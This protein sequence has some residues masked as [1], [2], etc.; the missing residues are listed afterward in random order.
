MSQT[1]QSVIEDGQ[2]EIGRVKKMMQS[3]ID[4]SLVVFTGTHG[5]NWVTEDCGANLRALNSGKKIHELKYHPSQRSWAL[6][7]GWTSCEDFD[8]GETCEIYKELY[9]TKDLGNSW[10]YLKNYIFDFSWG[11]TE[12]SVKNGKDLPDSR[13]FITHDPNAKGHQRSA[14]RWKQKVHL[15]YSDDFFKSQKTALDAGNSIVLTN[16]F[17]FVAKAITENTIKISVARQETGFLDFVL[18]RMPVAYHI[19]SHFT[20]MD[21]A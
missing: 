21:T 17:M 1:G 16:H 14:Q 6:A 4:N 20:V 8:D 12:V 2:T 19:T 3:P 7:A 10:Q 15:Y 18:V 9:I 13:I 5:V 11:S